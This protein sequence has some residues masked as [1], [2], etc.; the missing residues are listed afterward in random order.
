MVQVIEKCERRDANA[1]KW[2]IYKDG[3]LV[4]T[5]LHAPVLVGTIRYWERQ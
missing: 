5:V 3:K 2:E 4:D 1:P